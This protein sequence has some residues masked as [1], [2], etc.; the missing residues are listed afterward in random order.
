MSY[1]Y[2]GKIAKID[3]TNKKVDVETPD[4]Y[5]YRSYMGGSNIGAYYLLKELS[6]NIDPLSSDNIMVISTSVVTGI[7]SPGFSRSNVAAKSPLTGCFGESQAGGF[8]GPELKFSGYDALVIRGRAKSPCYIFIKDGKV[9]IKDAKELWG[10]DV[11]ETQEL[12][13]K[14]N[15]DA[16]IRVLTIGKG[17]ENLVRYACIISDLIHAHGRNGLGAVMASKNLKAVAAR[18][19][20]KVSV[21]DMDT[22]RQANKYFRDKVKDNPATRELNLYGTSS[23]IQP[24]NLGGMLP[25]YNFRTGYFEHAEDISGEK[26]ASTILIKNEGCYAC[27]VR[28]KR[29]VKAG[30]KYSTDPAFGGPEYETITAL[31]S[32]CGVSDLNAIAYANELCNKY[33]LDTISTGSVISFAMECFENGILTKSDTDG[34]ELG[35]GNADAMVAMVEKIAS[36]EG[37]GDILAEGVKRAAE[38]IG[39]GAEKFAMHVKGQE[40]PMHEPRAKGML[41]FSYAF[42]PTGADHTQAEH[43]SDFDFNAPEIFVEQAK[44]FGLLKRLETNSIDEKKVR[45]YCYLQDHFSF[46]D[47]LGLCLLAFAPVRVFKMKH[48]V[49]IVS[50]VTGWET[51]LWELMKSGEKRINM[52]KCFNAREGIDIKDD[53]LPNRMY[54]P[55]ESGARR[56]DKIDGDQFRYA[57]NLYYRIRNWDER[58]IPTKAILYEL[59]LGWV[60]DNLENHGVKL[61]L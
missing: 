36:R 12:I 48:I 31:G 40:L 17:A 30:G 15:N 49:D 59:D 35:F 23:I 18:G 45:E 32:N 4:E 41:A 9:E 54:E 26:M 53:V 7:P 3:L 20:A 22:I 25:S 21:K 43:D 29:V 38:Q 8:F 6:P 46:M 58:A 27:P 61:S 52:A 2:T 39:K 19:S 47:S 5:F 1:G 14:Q 33:T 10:K 50:A 13:R 55:L 37:L 11:K 28:C 57:Q 56:G 51:S 60:I 34:L 42:S 44:A 16:R 24:F